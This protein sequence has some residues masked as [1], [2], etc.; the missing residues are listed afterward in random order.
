MTYLGRPLCLV[1]DRQGA[2]ELGAAKHG[3]AESEPQAVIL[4]YAG[5]YLLNPLPELVF[6][7]FYAGQITQMTGEEYSRGFRGRWD[8]SRGGYATEHSEIQ[9]IR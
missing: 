3:T 8:F 5:E 9:I 6:V 2:E 7:S 1:T 4:P